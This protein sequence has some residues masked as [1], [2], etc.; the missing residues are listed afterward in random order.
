VIVKK[1]GI[2]RTVDQP[3]EKI[4]LYLLCGP[5]E[6]QARA[7]AGRLQA[8]LGAAKFALSAAEVRSNPAL[9]VDEA[10]AL[11]LFGERRLIW[12]EP[13]GNELADAVAGLLAADAIE[14][15]VV[16]I[17][18]SL[19]KA[20]PLL[21]LAESS[22]HAV[23]YTAYLPEGDEA[24]RIVSDLGRRVGLKIGE[25]VAGR[26]AESCGN[27][28]ALILRELEKLALYVG[29]SP[30]APRE[31][32]HE[33]IDAVGAE[34]GDGDMLRL[35]DLA[36]LGEAADLVD[37]LSRLLAGGS[38]GIPAIRSLLRRVQMLAPGRARVERGERIDAVL[39]SLGKAL[40]WKDKPSVEKMLRKW[41][42]DDLAKVAERAGQLERNLMF[43]QM[44]EREALG[45]ELLAIARK[46]RSAR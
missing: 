41:T 27:D 1:S 28:Q 39:T 35:G 13:A 32:E 15:P 45:E 14:S 29:A 7:L 8:A 16:A 3:D 43:S 40:F 5:D 33:A 22:P 30:N 23:A 38:E 10:A 25:A 20:S 46:A 6:G 31:L 4:R 2:G 12:I 44:P 36:L 42:A 24:L 9:L 26:I 34:S 17:A 21:K 37:A 18:G 19:T 11:S